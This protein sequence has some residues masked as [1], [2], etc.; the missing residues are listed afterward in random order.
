MVCAEADDAAA[1][2]AIEVESFIFASREID[3]MI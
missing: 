2:K 1:A 3:R